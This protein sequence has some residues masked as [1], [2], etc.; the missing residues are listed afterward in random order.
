MVFSILILGFIDLE[1]QNIVPP[2]RNYRLWE[3]N[4]ASKNWDVS[5]STTGEVFVANHLGL[6]HFDGERWTLNQLPNKTIVR[7]VLV[8][9]DKIF[10]GSY[11]EFGYWQ[12]NSLGALEYKS[13]AQLIPREGLKSEE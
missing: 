8:L 7:S 9:D 2:V 5:I 12:E 1:V 6:L 13:L 10:T 3:Y 11:E 4:G